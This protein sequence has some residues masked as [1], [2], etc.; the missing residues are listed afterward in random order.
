MKSPTHFS[1]VYLLFVR[2]GQL[3]MIRRFNT[4]FEDGNYSVVAGHIEHGESPTQAAVSEVPE[5]A[6]VEIAPS[7][8]EFAHIQHRRSGSEREY[9]DYYFWVR[10]WQGQPHKCEPDKPF[11]PPSHPCRL[12]SRLPL[13]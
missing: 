3:L 1:A 6:G 7:A 13:W 12:R 4:G 5:E 8:L 9:P 11:C 10:Q 2:N